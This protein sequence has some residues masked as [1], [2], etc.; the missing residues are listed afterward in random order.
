MVQFFTELEAFLY[1]D[2]AVKDLLNIARAGQTLGCSS[3]SPP[4]PTGGVV[5]APS[6]ELYLD[7]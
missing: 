7:D 1:R 3:A 4:S 2:L 5:G 6:A